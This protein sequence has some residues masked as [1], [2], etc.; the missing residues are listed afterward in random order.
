MQGVF[1]AVVEVGAAGGS[2]PVGSAEEGL[3]PRRRPG[4]GGGG[5]CARQPGWGCAPAH[6]SSHDQLACSIAASMF[7]RFD[8]TKFARMSISLW[9]HE[10]LVRMFDCIGHM[11][12]EDCVSVE[13]VRDLKKSEVMFWQDS[14]SS[15]SDTYASCMPC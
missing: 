11:L 7:N 6:E 13:A 8:C 12:L 1:R 14:C 15:D 4:S 9:M 10:V 5:A 2:R 3:W